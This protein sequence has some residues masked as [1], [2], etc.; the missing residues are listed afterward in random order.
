MPAA[1]RLDE[2]IGFRRAPSHDRDVGG[3]GPQ[4]V[5]PVRI[6]VYRLDLA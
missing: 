6:L 1:V 4:G 5:P 2:A 3:R